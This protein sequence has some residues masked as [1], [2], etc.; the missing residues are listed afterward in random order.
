MPPPPLRAPRPLRPRPPGEAPSIDV[1]QAQP[2]PGLLLPA[3]E[4]VGFQVLLNRYNRVLRQ[5]RGDYD[6]TARQRSA[7]TCAAAGSSTSDPFD[8]QPARPPVPGV[9]VPR[10]RALGGLDYWHSLG[11]TFV[12]S[13][14][15]E[16]AGE[17]TPPSRNDQVSDAASAAASSARR[18]SACR[19]WCSSRTRCRRFWREIARGGDL[20]A[21]GL[22]PARLRRSLRQVFPSRDPVYFSRLQIGY[23]GSA[24]NDAGRVDHAAQAQR[25]AGRLLHR[26]RPARQAGLRVHAAVRLLQLPGHG[27]ERQRL[28][29]RDDARPARRARATSAGERLSRRLGPVRQLRLHRAADLPRLDAP[30]CR[31]ARPAQWWLGDDDRA[32]GH[33]AGRRRL[34]RGRARRAAPTA[35]ATITTASRRRR[36]SRCASSSATRASLDLTGREYFVSRVAAAAP[37]RARQH[38]RA[39]T[40]RFTWRVCQAARDVAQVP[41]QPPRRQLSRSAATAPARQVTVGHLLHAARAGPVRRRSTGDNAAATPAA[42]RSTA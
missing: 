9:D 21:G 28:R 24:Q 18:C 8:D 12:G 37:R 20:A 4:I 25:G 1:E 5:Q 35:S 10:L 15:W 6:V 26:L 22:Q 34:R 2:Q 40:P 41:R 19:T 23:S 42:C 13:A 39:P 31:S 32:A 11:Y 27:V 33:G 29:E 14:L 30:R 3:L 17:T 7:A 36:C 38:R 16:I